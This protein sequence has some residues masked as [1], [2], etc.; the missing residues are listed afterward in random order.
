MIKMTKNWIASA[1][2]HPG[3]LRKKLKVK[4]GEKIPVKKL[5][6]AAKSSNP[7]TRRQANLAKTLRG[8][9]KQRAHNGL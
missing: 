6:K 2:K 4:P 9:R 1:I 7:T 3:A 8:L 5:D